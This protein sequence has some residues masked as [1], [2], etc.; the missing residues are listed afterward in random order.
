MIAFNPLI[1][2]LGKDEDIVYVDEF[3][4][5]QIYQRLVIGSDGKV[6]LCANDE[7]GN[8][9]LGDI[10][11]QSVYEI[12]HGERIN[13]IRELHSLGKFKDVDVCRK[14]YL[15]RATEDSE[16]AFVNDREITIQNYINR[17]Q[18]IGK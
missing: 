14:C 9:L 11:L 5:P 4:C 13:K 1:D 2:Y 17:T 10:N 12:W 16:H 8:Y 15:P 6:M 18:V 3:A 7:D